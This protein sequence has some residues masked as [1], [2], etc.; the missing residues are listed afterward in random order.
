M[1]KNSKV[2]YKRI[3]ISIDSDC[4]CPQ[5][6]RKIHDLLVTFQGNS[7]KTIE[8]LCPKT[9][10]LT[11]A[12][13]T[14]MTQ[15]QVTTSVTL[16]KLAKFQG[17]IHLSWGIIKFGVGIT[18]S[19]RVDKLPQLPTSLLMSNL[20]KSSKLLTITVRPKHF[21]TFVSRNSRHQQKLLKLDVNSII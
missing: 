1:A 10:I 11:R 4:E 6:T 16:S 19:W 15:F 9:K 18:N 8:N 13:I 21:S 7:D 12:V 2:G 5:L 17:D 14:I 20:F 3:T